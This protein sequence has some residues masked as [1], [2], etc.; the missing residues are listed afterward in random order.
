MRS[1]ETAQYFRRAFP[2]GP[3]GEKLTQVYGRR[4]VLPAVLCYLHEHVDT[5]VSISGQYT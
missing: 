3:L 1:R 4:F 2:L 5:V